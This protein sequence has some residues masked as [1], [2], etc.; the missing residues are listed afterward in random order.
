MI[1]WTKLRQ[2][3]EDLSLDSVNLMVTKVDVNRNNVN[4]NIKLKVDVDLN[5][6]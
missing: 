4:I 3:Q 6:G 5:K 1:K 2:M